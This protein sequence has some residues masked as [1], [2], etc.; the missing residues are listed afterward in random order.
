LKKKPDG[1]FEVS[2]SDIDTQP[3]NPEVPKTPNENANAQNTDKDMQGLDEAS[4]NEILQ[5]PAQPQAQASANSNIEEWEINK[6]GNLK[7]IGRECDKNFGIFLYDGSKLIDSDIQPK[8][9]HSWR[10]V[11]PQGVWESKM[12]RLAASSK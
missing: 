6:I 3:T 5:Q 10:E 4:M 12:S 9:N 2:I 8:A 7:L 11:I 1:T